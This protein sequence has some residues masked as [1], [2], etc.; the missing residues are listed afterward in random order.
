MWLPTKPGWKTTEAFLFLNYNWID[1]KNTKFIDRL[2][3]RVSRIMKSA[4][5]SRGVS[6][7]AEGPGNALWSKIKHEGAQNMSSQNL[8]LHFFIAEFSF[9]RVL[10]KV[11]NFFKAEQKFTILIPFELVLS[12]LLL[13]HPFFNEIK[14]FWVITH[15]W[16]AAS[17]LCLLLQTAHSTINTL[18]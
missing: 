2:T 10:C 14:E 16:T 8:F 1:I 3:I 5:V 12:C 9:A 18:F 4:S 6:S 17:L 15:E 7:A 11:F 13:P